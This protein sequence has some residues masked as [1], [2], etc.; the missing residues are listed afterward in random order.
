MLDVFQGGIH[1]PSQNFWEPSYAEFHFIYVS[2]V[3]CNELPGMKQVLDT[4]K[5]LIHCGKLIVP[6]KFQLS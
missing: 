5:L 6:A 1:S 3:K 4:L 2:T